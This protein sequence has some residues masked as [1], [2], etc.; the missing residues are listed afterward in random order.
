[1]KER[2]SILKNWGH[3]EN[4]DVWFWSLEFYFRYLQLSTYIVD[5]PCMMKGVG[6]PEIFKRKSKQPTGRWLFPLM[7]YRTKT[8]L[9]LS[10]QRGLGKSTS[11]HPTSVALVAWHCS[12]RD[13]DPLGRKGRQAH[14]K[15]LAT[16]ATHSQPGSAMAM[17]PLATAIF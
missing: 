4:P 5:V 12:C 10:N 2:C 1:M 11:G 15:E 14:S 16:H 13:S 3:S 6:S 8:H 7:K 9:T 17:A